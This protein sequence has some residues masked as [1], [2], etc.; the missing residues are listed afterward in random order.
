MPIEIR[1][2][3]IKATVDQGKS[4]GAGN[5]SAAG[6]SSNAAGEDMIRECVDKVLAI[7]KEQNER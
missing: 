4:S 6:G 2:L 3:V 7:L 5:S 1:E